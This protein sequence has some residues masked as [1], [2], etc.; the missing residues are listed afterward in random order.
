[1]GGMTEVRLPMFQNTPEFAT[2]SPLPPTALAPKVLLPDEGTGFALELRDQ[3]EVAL[4]ES[5]AVL[6]VSGAEM[7]LPAQLMPLPITPFIATQDPTVG[8]SDV[9]G[10]ETGQPL[11]S[12]QD[13]ALVHIGL[14]PPDLPALPD[15]ISPT[16]SIPDLPPPARTA[17]ELPATNH[18]PVSAFVPGQAL[19]EDQGKGGESAQ[20]AIGQPPVGGTEDLAALSAQGAAIDSDSQPASAAIP[21]MMSSPPQPLQP[22]DGAAHARDSAKPEKT[23]SPPLEMAEIASTDVLPHGQDGQKPSG[24][25]EPETARD[26]TQRS[27]HPVT[28][29]VETTAALPATLGES[30]LRFVWQD[31]MMESQPT[32][33]SMPDLAPDLPVTTFASPPG[34]LS[35]VVDENI[36]SSASAAATIARPRVAGTEDAGRAEIGA[37]GTATPSGGSV[38]GGATLLTFSA[39]DQA[40]RAPANTLGLAEDDPFMVRPMPQSTADKASHQAEVAPDAL[41]SDPKDPAQ[42]EEPQDTSLTLSPVESGQDKPDRRDSFSLPAVNPATTEATA[43]GQSASRFAAPLQV[44][45]TVKQVAESIANRKHDTP[46]KIELTL[47]PETLG[48]VH[49]EMR[50]DKNGLSVTLS[51]ERQDTLDLIRRHLPDLVSELKQTGIQTGSF[52]FSGW[53]E[54]RHAPAPKPDFDTAAP[55]VPLQI[56]PTPLRPKPATPLGKLDLRV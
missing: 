14:A 33:P 30:A 34:K 22:I 18:G 26:L 13:P 46:G 39:I 36:G 43:P 20:V 5:S 7:M 9:I 21:L 40:S 42:A 32:S 1:M 24:G 45:E 8:A 51:A 52:S 44:P 3:T 29:L 49:F 2:L 16:D 54:G 48:R 15:Q 4:P 35:A 38:A 6:A 47:T 10:A 19:P 53:Q 37:V 23:G 41:P 55:V 27:A 31:R 11:S 12:S 50:T 25:A 28:Q 17:Q 56:A